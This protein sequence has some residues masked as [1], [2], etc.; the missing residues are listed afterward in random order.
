MK[1]VQINLYSINELSGDALANA[2]AS[3]KEFL[4]SQYSNDMFDESL[5]YTYSMYKKDLTK[6]NIIEDIEL[7]D[8]L[9]FANGELAHTVKYV[10]NHPE[11]G[12]H[13]LNL[14]GESFNINESFND[15]KK[16]NN[17]KKDK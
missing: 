1:K 16:I 17:D 5:N 13:I 7:N 2:I 8:Y 6:K 14:N 12:K 15:D 10:A 9:Y 3:H 11:A 4:L